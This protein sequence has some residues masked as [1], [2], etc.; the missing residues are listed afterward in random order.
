MGNAE[1]K[2]CNSLIPL[3]EKDLLNKELSIANIRLS[4]LTLWQY[5]NSKKVRKEGGSKVTERIWF[6]LGF[7]FS[8]ILCS[9]SCCKSFNSLILY[10]FKVILPI[11]IVKQQ[12]LEKQQQQQDNRGDK[13]A[14]PPPPPSSTSAKPPDVEKQLE[15]VQ[16]HIEDLQVGGGGEE[17]GRGFFLFIGDI[18][19]V[20]KNNF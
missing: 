14:P 5:V 13:K 18:F 4:I 9:L 6:S 7:S 12:K 16:A 11:D 1:E 17:E 20:R 19:R 15:A 8:A 10:S 3:A 2:L